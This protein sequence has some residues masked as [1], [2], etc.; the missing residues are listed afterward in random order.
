MS[1]TYYLPVL[2]TEEERKKYAEWGI[3]K[4]KF[5]MP[6]AVVTIII[7]LIV[8]VGTI[9]ALFKIREKEPYFSA[10]LST[11][12][13]LINDI[14]YGVAIVLTVL[15][16]KP[17]DMILDMVYKKPQEPQML[18]LTPTETGVR[19]MLSR[20]VSVRSSGTL[21][22]NDWERAISTETNEIHIGDT[23][24]RI[25]F[26]TI[27]SIYPKNKQ[28]P[29]MDRPK[30]KVENSI[31]LKTISRNFHGYLLSLEEKKKEQAYIEKVQ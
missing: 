24:Y 22:W 19:Y 31:Y 15:L 29:W 11:Y 3:K 6:F 23:I 28:H 8:M 5:L 30:E 1:E 12:G 13:G 26:N 27:E 17:L 16:I 21:N 10:F 2:Y 25:G 18:C 14:A 4:E 9:V 7:D 20:G